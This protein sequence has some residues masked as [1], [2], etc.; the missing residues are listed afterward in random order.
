MGSLKYSP[1]YKT[2]CIA[3]GSEAENNG[4]NVTYIFSSKYR[5]MLSDEIISK[6]MFIGVTSNIEEM[7]VDYFKI[8]IRGYIKKIIEKIKPDLIYMHNY[9][10]L[11]HELLN[12]AL[13]NKIRF[14]YH[15]HEPHTADKKAHGRKQQIWLYGFEFFQD[16]LVNKSN[17]IVL[18]SD[19]AV[20]VFKKSFKS[21]KGKII[22]IP[23]IYEDLYQKDEK[24]HREY[25]TFIGP[26]VPAK[27]PEIFIKI[28]N[29][30]N[31]NNLGY[32]FL[33][34][35]GRSRIDDPKVTN[36]PNLTIVDKPNIS[37]EEFGQWIR[38]SK[39][40]ITPYKRET[41]SSV[42]LVSYMHGTPVV[43]SKVGGIPEFVSEKTGICLDLD[44]PITTWVNAIKQLEAID[45]ISTHC[46]EYFMNNFA[47]V[48]WGKYLEE[49]S[50]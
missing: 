39:C 24:V 18:S 11:N 12:Q 30:S 9:H 48:N 13:K 49:I 20:Q 4:H 15:L 8:L 21:Y 36:I 44:T 22:K 29:Y 27:N 38:K 28:M 3:F 37:D 41:Q 50:K 40:V 19:Y 45:N 16:R 25:I 32:K 23:L 14:M 10:L 47:S 26:L 17:I 43:T 2:H 31:D 33:I 7:F 1:V 46:R 6:T 42:I 5:W 35:S 34:I